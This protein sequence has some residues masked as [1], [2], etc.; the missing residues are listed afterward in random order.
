MA[1]RSRCSILLIDKAFTSREALYTFGSGE[2]PE[3]VLVHQDAHYLLA[4]E[5]VPG[6]LPASWLQPPGP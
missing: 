4:W 1:R 6:S 2:H 5:E 3:I